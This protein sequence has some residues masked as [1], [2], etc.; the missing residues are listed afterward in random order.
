MPGGSDAAGGLEEV[1]GEFLRFGLGSGGG[2]HF[3]EIFGGFFWLMRCV[4]GE[5]MGIYLLEEREIGEMI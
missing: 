4:E 5:W 2:G 3:F 1:K